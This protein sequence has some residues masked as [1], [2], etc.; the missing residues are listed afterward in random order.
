LGRRKDS[1]E[2]QKALLHSGA[3]FEKLRRLE[4]PFQLKPLS[5]RTGFRAMHRPA[6]CGLR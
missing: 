1:S 4:L 3:D 6:N 5:R 2:L